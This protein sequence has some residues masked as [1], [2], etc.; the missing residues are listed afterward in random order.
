MTATV[1]AAAF[2]ALYAGHQVGD[3]VTG[4]THAQA[5]GKAQSKNW[6]RPMLGHLAGY[7][8]TLAAFL[9]ALA[10]AGVRMSW[11]GVGVALLFSAATHG[12]IDRR[13]PVRWYLERTGSAEFA[14]LTSNGM[15]GMYLADQA[16]HVGC[17]F[18][19]ALIIGGM[20]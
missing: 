7:H 4:Q 11:I 12:F 19:S 18:I 14:Q 3:H 8:L 1:I 5:L 13:W 20:S 6:L 16:L 15:N 17:L 2:A 9:G 10:V